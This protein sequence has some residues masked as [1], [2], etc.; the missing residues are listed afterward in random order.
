MEML[1]GILVVGLLAAVGLSFKF[2]TDEAKEKTKTDDAKAKR[3]ADL[4]AEL[5]R[6]D[7]ELK[8]A[9]GEI[10]RIEDA[11]YQAKNDVDIAKKESSELTAR[12]KQAEKTKDDQGQTREDLKQK[13][14]MLEQETTARQKL[15]GEISLRERELEKKSKS[16][17]ELEKKLTEVQAQLKTKTEMYD[18]LKGQLAELEAEPPETGGKPP[19]PRPPMSEPPKPEPVR[20]EPPKPAPTKPEPPKPESPKPKPPEDSRGGPGVGFT[21]S[22]L[23]QGI[24]SD[25]DFLKAKPAPKP[26]GLAGDIPEGTFKITNINKPE[27][28]PSSEDEKRKKDTQ[29]PKPNRETLIPGFQ[30]KEKRLPEES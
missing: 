17:E 12:L 24:P 18:G 30:P 9:L 23:K 25:T 4:E 11:Y 15:Q 1:I 3:I 28:P 2:S 13:G 16:I 19:K 10:Q 8:K 7:Q 27:P 6:K 26:E 22:E 5:G 21:K 20:P 29:N 14:I